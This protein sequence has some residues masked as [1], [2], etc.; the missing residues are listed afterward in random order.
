MSTKGTRVY[1]F[2]LRPDSTA[3][4]ALSKLHLPCMRFYIQI[5][6][7]QTLYGGGF[8]LF[9]FV[10]DNMVLY[11]FFLPSRSPISQSCLKFQVWHILVT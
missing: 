7:I 5:K 11:F 2:S 9:V 1:S 6:E 10:V 4:F 3:G 8:C